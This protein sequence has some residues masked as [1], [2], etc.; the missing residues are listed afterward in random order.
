MSLLR[1]LFRK[2]RVVPVLSVSGPI[3]NMTTFWLEK[4]LE[5]ITRNRGIVCL[6]VVVDSQGGSGVQADIIAERLRAVCEQQQVP[7]YAFVGSKALSAA[8]LPLFAA[9]RT[10]C[11]RS[12][13]L[14]KFHASTF[15]FA[16]TQD[17]GLKRW[18]SP[19]EG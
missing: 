5:L 7:L 9:D 10:F 14:G 1:G 17:F 18:V 13:L 11:Q 15:A 2:S 3:D 12:S 4:D 16:L 6:A 19:T 8:A